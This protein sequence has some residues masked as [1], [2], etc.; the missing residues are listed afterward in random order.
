MAQPA[1]RGVKN[2]IKYVGSLGNQ[3][4]A[5]FDFFLFEREDFSKF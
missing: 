3:S 4:D 1:L 5:S 2:E